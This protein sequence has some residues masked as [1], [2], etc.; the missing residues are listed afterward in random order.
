MSVARLEGVMRTCLGPV[1]ARA[2]E[3][4]APEGLIRDLK[5]VEIC[6]Q[7]CVD[8]GDEISPEYRL[9]IVVR[10]EIIDE[11]TIRFLARHPAG[12]VVNLGAGLDT[13]MGR[14]DNGQARWYDVDL[15][16][17]IELRRQFFDEH[18]RHTM[19]PASVL[20]HRW[21]D[22]IPVHVPT[23]FIIEGLVNYL[24]EEDVRA[25]VRAMCDRF[26]SGEIFMEVLGLL[27]VKFFNSPVHRWGL[28]ADNFPTRWHERVE[29]V[30]SWCVYGRRKEQWAQYPWM[31][32]FEM[33]ENDAQVVLHLRVR[34]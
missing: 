4:Q 29:L 2:D 19:I 11:A 6:R 3:T 33:F 7:I 30:D 32:F 13:R 9:G 10:T 17:V 31:V 15:P 12:V 5:A 22:R 18:E 24:D 1:T 28:C 20:D 8:L 21:M 16:P 26:P 23:L 27:L 25:L 14:L 34:T